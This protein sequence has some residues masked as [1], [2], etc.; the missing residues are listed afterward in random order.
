[1]ATN[2][3]IKIERRGVAQEEN[4][5]KLSNEIGLELQVDRIEVP[6]GPYWAYI[7]AKQ[8]RGGYVVIENQF[9]KTDHDHLGKIITYAATLGA[10]AIVWIAERFTDEHKKAIEW[11]NEHTSV[12]LS[13]YAVEIE[14][15]QIDGSKPAVRFNVLSR[16][17]EIARQANAAICFRLGPV[18][19]CSR[20]FI[21]RG[22]DTKPL[23]SNLDVQPV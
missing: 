17:T 2:Y 11:L 1:M 23:R 3:N 9:G 8:S 18:R 16:P 7:L 4:I 12:D 22:S 19:S 21:R 15:W 20:R 5:A 14:L 6:V 10:T 13:M